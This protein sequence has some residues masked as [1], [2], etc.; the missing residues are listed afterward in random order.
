MCRTDE[1]VL[2][3]VA[4]DVFV[5]LGGGQILL[6]VLARPEIATAMTSF[7]NLDVDPYRRLVSTIQA[8]F[9][10]G[11][12][13]DEER[14][15]LAIHLRRV[16]RPVRGDGWR[17]ND[18][19]LLFFTLA[20]IMHT[21]VGVFED[22]ARPLTP[23]ERDAFYRTAV[24]RSAVLG[25]ADQ[26]PPDWPAFSA[27]FENQMTTCAATEA[28]RSL[29]WQI[30]Y[31]P[32][33]GALRSVAWLWRHIAVNGL[34][35]HLREQYGVHLTLGEAH[36]L[37][38]IAAR[39]RRL[40]ARF[41]GFVWDIGHDAFAGTDVLYSPPTPDRRPVSSWDITR[42]A[43]RSIGDRVRESLL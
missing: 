1:A 29:R 18:P 3:E 43:A 9:M 4:R 30:L 27:W 35:P 2:A 13:T 26:A 8:T 17:A 19:A 22:F 12:G 41:P 20:C 37:E 11:F 14:H 34:P 32:R 36:R 42:R 38:K 39:A 6:L 40:H 24:T 10:L 23:E 5:L 16:H 33:P 21:A 25:I 28:A 31:P 15:D 7:G